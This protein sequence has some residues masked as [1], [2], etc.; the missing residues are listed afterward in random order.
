[1]KQISILILFIGLSLASKADTVYVSGQIT[2]TNVIGLF[3][4][5]SLGG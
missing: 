4:L 5:P 1:M 3:W 2:D